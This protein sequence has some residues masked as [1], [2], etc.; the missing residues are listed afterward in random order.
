[1]MARGR[2]RIPVDK[3]QYAEDEKGVGAWMTSGHWH[4]LA[5]GRQLTSI[6]APSRI[7]QAASSLRIMH[8]DRALRTTGGQST[9]YSTD[10]TFHSFPTH[11]RSPQI[12]YYISIP[13]F[14]INFLYH[15]SIDSTAL[16]SLPKIA[17]NHFF[18]QADRLTTFI[19]QL[20]D[21]GGTTRS[22]SARRIPA[23]IKGGTFFPERH[24]SLPQAATSV[25]E[26]CG[27]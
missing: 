27:R 10:I 15:Y 26:C 20:F 5:A 6:D 22:T 14:S 7:R 1:M 25:L 3:R 9:H 17:L 4:P 12:S 8:T 24:T 19:V 23:A 11:C 13:P 2:L 21:K 16:P 18:V